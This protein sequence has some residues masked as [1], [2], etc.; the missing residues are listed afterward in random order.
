MGRIMIIGLGPGNPQYLTLAAR[1]AL[2]KGHP[3][4]FRT[5]RHPLARRL[6]DQG[7]CVHTFDFLYRTGA[8]FNRVYRSIVRRLIRIAVQ[9]KVVYYAVPGHPMI[10][11][12]TV[13]QLRRIAPKHGLVIK[14]IPGLSF[15]EPVLTALNLDLLEGVTVLDALALEQLKEPHPRHLILAQVYSKAVASRV[16]LR[17]LELYPPSFP[18]V[19]LRAAGLAEQQLRRVPLYALDRQRFNHYTTL[20]LPPAEGYSLGDLVEI[21]ARLRAPW[22]C[23]WDRE[24]THHTLRQYLV[25]EA[26]EVIAAIDQENDASLKEE[27]GDLLLQVIFHSQIARE[28][29]RFDLNQVI[30]A[31]SKKLIRRHPHVFARECLDSISQ[32]IHRWEQIKSQEKGEQFAGTLNVEAGLPALIRA[33]KVQQRAAE[34]GF[35][36]PRI[37]GAVDK[38]KEEVIELEDAYRQGVSGKIEEEFGDFLFAAVNVARFLQINPELALGKA[39]LK[40]LKRFRYIR[41]QVDKSKRPIT[42]YPLEQLDRWWEE[43]KQKGKKS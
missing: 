1:K 24:Q 32:V 19:V 29:G 6:R 30:G 4:Y 31:I 27:L 41:E 36:W 38:L 13:E 2:S 8:D 16:K 25:E 35:D 37:E 23:P 22:G 12:A 3:V 20:Y 33:Y 17:L 10:G 43:A 21:M 39:L 28:E 5:G 14:I 15:I 40:F 26:Y 7:V 18:V 9:R 42:S 11:E 34:L